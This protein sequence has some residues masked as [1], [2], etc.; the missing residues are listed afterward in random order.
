MKLT[1]E[2][3]VERSKK[4]FE[5]LLALVPAMMARIKPEVDKADYDSK[6]KIIM[7]HVMEERKIVEKELGSPTWD[8]MIDYEK[9]SGADIKKCFAAHPDKKKAG[10]ELMAKLNNALRP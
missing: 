1:P 7:A 5:R 4:M 3:Y 10:D 8:E 9:K 6:Q 2:T